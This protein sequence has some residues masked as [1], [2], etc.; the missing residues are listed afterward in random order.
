MKPAPF[1]YL[2][3]RS[4]QEALT[5]LAEDGEAKVLAGGQSLIPVLNMRLASPATLVDINRI[6]HRQIEDAEGLGQVAVSES[7]VRVGALVRH[8]HLE[9]DESAYQR[10]P[11]LRLALSQV[12]HPAIRNRGTTVGSI[13]HADPAGDMP[14]IL[15]LLKGSVSIASARG[16][17]VVEA[18]DFFQGPME[19]DLAQDE[20][21]THVTFT[22]TP[23]TGAA[24]AEVA[25]RHGDYALCGVGATVVRDPDNADHVLDAAVSFVSTTPVPTRLDLTAAFATSDPWPAVEEAVNEHIEPESD[26]HASA[27]YRRQLALTLTRRVLR[28]ALA[29]TPTPA[30]EAR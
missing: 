25:R 4:V 17:R 9:A 2:A 26:L 21:V 8:A 29:A 20:L 18:A 14:A 13:A 30:G 11:L 23:G 22:A 27:D 12:A 5:M 19:A 28:E 10:I 1:R 15:V 24:Y 3:P 6:G 16:T 7:G